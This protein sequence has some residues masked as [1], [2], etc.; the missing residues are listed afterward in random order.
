MSD[1][2]DIVPIT[3]RAVVRIDDVRYVVRGIK[4]KEMAAIVARFPALKKI[5]GGGAL[6]NED[7]IGQM[8][9][10]CGEAAAP[11][12]AAALGHVGDPEYE[13][14]IDNNLLVEQQLMFIQEIMALTFPN[15]IG[16]F[17]EALSR[18]IGGAPKE[19]KPVKVRLRRSPSTSPLSSD[20]DSRPTMQ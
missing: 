2:L 16:S 8:I 3:S 1:L 11:I 13:Q 5:A 12:I 19:E 7:F 18:L 10:A 4:I 17:I 6:T 15:G 9:I 14:R 20:A